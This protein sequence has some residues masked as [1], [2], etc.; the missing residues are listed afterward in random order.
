MDLEPEFERLPILLVVCFK[1][2]FKY[3]LESEIYQ[4]ATVLN[5]AIVKSW[6]EEEFCQNLVRKGLHSL[7][8]VYSRFF[9][10]D[11]DNDKDTIVLESPQPTIQQTDNEA[12]F[13]DELMRDGA[14][15]KKILNLKFIRSKLNLIGKF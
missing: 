4:A 12:M 15:K 1:E 3:E 8:L 9:F 13:F 6:I 2:K 5:L 10:D 14:M 11:T 7:K